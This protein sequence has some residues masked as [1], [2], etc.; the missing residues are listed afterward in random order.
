MPITKI[1]R[2]EQEE[3]A[4]KLRELARRVSE[5]SMAFVAVHT[6]DQFGL[7]EDLFMKD[8]DAFLSKTG[9]R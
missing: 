8:D 7:A 1:K 3:C 4:I 6:I 2:T 9:S 5:G